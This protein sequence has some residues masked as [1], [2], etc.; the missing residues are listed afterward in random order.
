VGSRGFRFLVILLLLLLLLVRLVEL[1][2][3]Y[4]NDCYSGVAVIILYR[5]TLHVVWMCVCVC[6]CVCVCCLLTLLLLC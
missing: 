3:F 4:V 6:V 5:V 1:Q 2:I